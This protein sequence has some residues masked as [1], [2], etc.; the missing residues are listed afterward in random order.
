ML[1]ERMFP[2]Q[3]DGQVPSPNPPH[4]AT[5]LAG[6]VPWAVAEKAYETY[7]RLYG[8]DQTLERLAER[9]GFAWSELVWLLQGAQRDTEG[10]RLPMTA[11][12]AAPIEHSARVIPSLL[13][14]DTLARQAQDHANTIK[15]YA[16]FFK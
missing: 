9:G 6:Y 16:Q 8:T 11:A 2:I 12:G 13:S 15:L 4:A 7:A 14:L 3:S 10:Q 1:I 5:R